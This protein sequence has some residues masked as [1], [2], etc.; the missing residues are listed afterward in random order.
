MLSC[1]I[2]EIQGEKSCLL[3]ED[4]A[5]VAFS[6]GSDCHVSR[7]PSEFFSDKQQTKYYMDGGSKLASENGIWHHGQLNKT[8]FT[9]EFPAA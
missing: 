7:E 3:R 9:P 1:F 4:S 8:N 5:S 2:T 6:K